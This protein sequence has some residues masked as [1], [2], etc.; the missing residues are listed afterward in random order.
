MTQTETISPRV[1]TTPQAA[2]YLGRSATWL[3]EHL[4][5]LKEK[6]FP[7]PL[8]YVKGFDRVAIDNWLEGLGKGEIR[9]QSNGRKKGSW[10]GR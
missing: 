1:L 7:D 6:G 10:T 2:K 5:E 9:R 4:P 8:P 3:R